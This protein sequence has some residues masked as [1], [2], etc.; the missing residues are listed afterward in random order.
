M[1]SVTP[2]SIAGR[3]ETSESIE[4]IRDMIS[5]FM[6]MAEAL[7]GDALGRTW[8]IIRDHTDHPDLKEGDAAFVEKRKPRWAPFTG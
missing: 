1:T 8:D 3:K 4:A 6:A 5:Q 7:L 2:T